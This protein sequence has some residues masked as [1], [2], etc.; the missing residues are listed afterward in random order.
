VETSGQ[1][2][3][4]IGRAEYF[5]NG[6]SMNGRIDIAECKFVGWKVENTRVILLTEMLMKLLLTRDLTVGVHVP[7]TQQQDQLVLGELGIDFNERDH[8]EC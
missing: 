4:I 2:R 1:E 7:L 6:P 8:V 5:T 3:V